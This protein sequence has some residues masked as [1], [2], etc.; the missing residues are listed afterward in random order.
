MGLR[1]TRGK[2]NRRRPRESGDPLSV[3]WIPA[4]AGMTQSARFSG[5]FPW[6]CGPLE[7]MKIPS[8]S[9]RRGTPW[10][11]P[12]MAGKGDFREIGKESKAREPTR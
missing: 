2:E 11:A 4:F 1:P 7:Q 9:S 5:E 3:Q 12:T 8:A 6:A 10:R